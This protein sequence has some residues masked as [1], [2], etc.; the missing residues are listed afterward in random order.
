M[1]IMPSLSFYNLI[2]LTTRLHPPTIISVLNDQL[3]QVQNYTHDVIQVALFQATCC[4]KYTQVY[5]WCSTWRTVLLFSLLL[6][7]RRVMSDKKS[8]LTSSRAGQGLDWRIKDA[9][10]FR[11][12]EKKKFEKH[13]SIARHNLLLRLRCQKLEVDV[14]LVPLTF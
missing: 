8:F 14:W 1:L 6:L 11:I 4:K 10:T 7:Q 3:L 2:S 9:T 13:K 12:T 5:Y